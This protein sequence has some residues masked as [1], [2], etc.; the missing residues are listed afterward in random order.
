MPRASSPTPLFAAANRTK[1]VGARMPSDGSLAAQALLLGIVHCATCGQKMYVRGRG[2]NGQRQAFYSCARKSRVGEPKCENPANADAK[3]VNDYVVWVLGQDVSGA[4]E[5]VGTVE[6]RWLEAREALH[7]APPRRAA[8]RSDAA[9]ADA[10]ARMWE[11]ERSADVPDEMVTLDG[12][13]IPYRPRGEDRDA[14]CRLPL[15]RE[16]HSRQGNRWQ[17]LGQRVKV[18]WVDGLEPMLADDLAA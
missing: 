16:G 14:D 15:H 18:E 10:R 5:G 2:R 1:E 6:R 11:L 12:R 3:M 9:V 8:P 17:P 13:L 4:C 7:A